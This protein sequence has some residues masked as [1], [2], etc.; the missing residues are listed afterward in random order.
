MLVF[1]FFVSCV[2]VSVVSVGQFSNLEKA[3]FGESCFP[4]VAMEVSLA[5]SSLILNSVCPF[6]LIDLVRFSMVLVEC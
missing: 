3:M 6:T 2:E 4:Y 1:L 5:C